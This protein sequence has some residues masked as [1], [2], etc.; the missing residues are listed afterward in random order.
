MFPLRDS[1][2]SRRFPF[3]NL[4]LIVINIFIFIQELR[5]HQA[6]A[7]EGFIMAHGLVPSRFLV[8]PTTQWVTVFSSMFM[9]GGWAHVLGNMWFLYVFGD[10]VEDSVGHLRYLIYYLLMGIGAAAFQVAANPSGQ[11]PMVG[12][13]GAIA[14]VLGSYI[15]LHPGARVDT[16]VP[17]FIFIRVIQLPAYFFLGLWFVVQMVNGLGSVSLLAERG[18]MGGVAWWAHAGGFITGFFAIWVFRRR[19]HR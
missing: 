8:D 10:N 7:L 12:A 15:V 11:L 2:P 17:I 3:V 6:G 9:H 19:H 4:T 14:G 18:E 5:L 13:S 1:V 16:L